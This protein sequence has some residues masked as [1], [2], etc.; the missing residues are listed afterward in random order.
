MKKE[1]KAANVTVGVGLD[2]LWHAL[3]KDL[4]V[5]LPKLMPNLVK[6]AKVIE[7]DGGL[8]S[9][10][11]FTFGSEVEA[12]TYQKE[13]VTDLDESLHRIGL[14]V[15]EGGFLEVR[16]FSHYKTI[17]QLT[18][19]IGEQETAVDVTVEYESQA[20]DDAIP[21]KTLS[22]SLHFI[23]CLENHLLNGTS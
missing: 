12:I 5:M 21:T 13:K 18:A 6:D 3:S 16:K 14:Q 17:F 23:K 1:V 9:I 8:G 15:I 22:A 10:F 20:E 19:A 2:I 4:K 11:L 7:G